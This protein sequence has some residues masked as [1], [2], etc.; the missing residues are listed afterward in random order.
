MLNLHALRTWHLRALLSG[1]SPKDDLL[2]GG[3]SVT[4]AIYF[5]HEFKMSIFNEGS[6]NIQPQKKP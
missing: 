1:K 3:I 5:P 2:C 6:R 4:W